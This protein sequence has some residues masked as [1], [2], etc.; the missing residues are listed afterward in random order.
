MASIKTSLGR[1][2]SLCPPH[3]RSDS[4]NASMVDSSTVRK[5][6]TQHPRQRDQ[7]TATVQEQQNQLAQQRLSLVNAVKIVDDWHR[8]NSIDD[9][10]N[11]IHEFYTCVPKK[12]DQIKK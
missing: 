12:S 11:E 5:S 7:E 9:S 2:V 10:S 4:P 8:R 6:I 3:E 1:R